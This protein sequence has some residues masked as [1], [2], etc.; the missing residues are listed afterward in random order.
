[1]T[2]LQ[3]NPQPPQFAALVVVLVSQPLTALLS[4]SPKGAAQAMPQLP[5]LHWGAPPEALH[6][7]VQFPQCCSSLRR[8]PSQPLVASPSQ[9]PQNAAQVIPQAPAA[10][11]AVPCAELHAVAQAPQWMASACRF[12]SQP[13]NAWLSQLP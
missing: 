5:L 13:L 7:P 3:A 12:V 2:V 6:L 1:M 10:Q 4:Q 11:L 9:L 8:S